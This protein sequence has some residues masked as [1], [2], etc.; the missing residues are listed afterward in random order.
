MFGTTHEA[1]RPSLGLYD[2]EG[3]VRGL[4]ALDAEGSPQLLA[5]GDDLALTPVDA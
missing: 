1:D 4:L 2:G 3:N 5:V